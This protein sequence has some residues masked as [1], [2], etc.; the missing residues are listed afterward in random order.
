[1]AKMEQCSGCAGYGLISD[2]HGGDFN[3]AME[4]SECEGT[5][6]VRPRDKKGRFL[7]IDRPEY[8]NLCEGI[9]LLKEKTQ[10][11]HKECPDCKGFGITYD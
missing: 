4:C 7:P 8:C 2:Y 11:T 6:Y 10:L 9:G 5:G 1:M 3:G